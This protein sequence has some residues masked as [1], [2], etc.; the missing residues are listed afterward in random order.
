MRRKIWAALAS[1]A[2]SVLA[3]CSC[4]HGVDQ[5]K[6]DHLGGWCCFGTVP[7]VRQ[8]TRRSTRACRGAVRAGEFDSA[9]I[10]A[11]VAAGAGLHLRTSTKPLFGHN[12]RGDPGPNFSPTLTASPRATAPAGFEFQGLIAGLVEL[13]DRAGTEFQNAPERLA[14]SRPAL[15]P[16]LPGCAAGC[17]SIRGDRRARES[18]S[19]VR[20]GLAFRPGLGVRREAARRRRGWR[21]LG[22]GRWGEDLVG[23]GRAA[24]SNRRSRP[25]RRARRISRGTTAA[26]AIT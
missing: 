24:R 12:H 22:C 23:V 5:W 18:A 26:S 3:G 1:L 14:A 9:G 25:D 11:G 15:P 21:W 16:R 10:H 4:L 2:I 7:T 8:R 13:D 6:C 17:G 20:R 19:R